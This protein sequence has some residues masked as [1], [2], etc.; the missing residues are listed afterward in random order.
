MTMLAYPHKPAPTD[1]PIINEIR[2][3]WSPRAFSEM[4]VEQQKIDTLFEAARWAPSNGNNQEW[5]FLYATKGDGEDRAILESLLVEGNA[6]AKNAYILMIGF[7]QSK[8]KKSDGTMTENTYALF[9]TGM[10]TGYLA[11]QCVQLGLIGHQMAGFDREHANEILGVPTDFLP[12]S[13]MA[14]GYPADLSILSEQLQE[15]EKAPRVRKE[16]SE[17]VFRGKW[18]G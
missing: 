7:A 16:Q 11:L 14:I 1:L 12:A 15:R 3:R 8:R 13:M 17:F 9:D 4:P 18:N 2:Q 10:A 5:N 6:W